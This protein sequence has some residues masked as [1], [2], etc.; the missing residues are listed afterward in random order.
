[1]SVASGGALF[2]LCPVA[3]AVPR[4]LGT[5]DPGAN[6]GVPMV[7]FG[8]LA[9]GVGSG[10]AALREEKRNDAHRRERL[11]ALGGIALS[12]FG[13]IFTYACL[14]LADEV[15]SYVR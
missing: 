7:A 11:L 5:Y 8:L 1:M 12:A 3:E 6:I 2:V 9:Y 4:L 14:Y 15:A 13:I 10:V